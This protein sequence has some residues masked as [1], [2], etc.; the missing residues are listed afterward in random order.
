MR[1]KPH[2]RLCCCTEYRHGGV[3]PWHM[4]CSLRLNCRRADIWYNS[5]P[6][7]V[8]LFKYIVMCLYVQFGPLH[9]SPQEFHSEFIA[10]TEESKR[11]TPTFHISEHT[12]CSLCVREHVCVCVCV[13]G[14]C[15]RQSL[16]TEP[17]FSFHPVLSFTLFQS[18]LINHALL[19]DR[20]R[21]C[22][23]LHCSPS[24]IQN[25]VLMTAVS[26]C[27]CMCV[28]ICVGGCVYEGCSRS[29]R[30]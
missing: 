11:K 18:W 29:G 6:F 20:T 5:T 15:M 26:M 16:P 14:L 8:T 4:A 19:R 3:C 1:A 10:K 23:S 9:S 12:P 24:T 28:W 25:Q 2:W 30:Q 27:V 22:N 21:E 7:C 13:A 17:L